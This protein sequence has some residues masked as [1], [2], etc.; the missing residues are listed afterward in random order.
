MVNKPRERTIKV[1]AVGTPNTCNVTFTVD[2]SDLKFKNKINGV[3]HP[4]YIVYF[5]LDETSGLDCKFHEPDPMWVEP[6][7]PGQS[8]CPSS[9]C[10][11]DQFRTIDV[12]NGGKTLMVRNENDYEHDF[13]FTL[14]FD[15]AGCT[16]VLECDPIGN[17]ENGQQN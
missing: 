1:K 10:S 16:R 5:D 2:A 6:I 12:I 4:G 13:A 7:A 8:A 9:P 17:N 14:R 15:V 11:W 3:G